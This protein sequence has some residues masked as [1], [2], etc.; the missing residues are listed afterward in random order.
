MS[1]E[2][3]IKGEQPRQV[4]KKVGEAENFQLIGDKLTFPNGQFILTYDFIEASAG[5]LKVSFIPTI[6]Q[7]STNSATY[8]EIAKYVVSSKKAYLDALLFAA[9]IPGSGIWRL[10]IRGVVKFADKKFQN[11]LNFDLP[12]DSIDLAEGD[13]VL[14]EGKSDGAITVL[15]DGVI[16]AREVT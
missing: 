8:Q 10:T 16:Q 11:I 3:Q 7:V 2:K 5:K 9:D 15:F 4:L 12:G 13:I 1:G 6:E 14:I